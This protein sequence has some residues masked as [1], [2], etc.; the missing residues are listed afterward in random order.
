M[1]LQHIQYRENTL[2]ILYNLLLLSVTSF[3]QK[4]IFFILN[5][6][7][8]IIPAIH[9]VP[10]PSSNVISVCM[11]CIRKKHFGK[12]ILR[13]KILMLS[14]HLLMEVLIRR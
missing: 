3:D 10:P 5:I 11:T 8:Y 1:L 12:H 2:C 6:T 13:T 14:F 9:C 4:H 7:S